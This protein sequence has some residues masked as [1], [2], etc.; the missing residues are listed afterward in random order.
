MSN[1]TTSPQRC[2]A[3]TLHFVDSVLKILEQVSELTLSPPKTQQQQQQQQDVFQ[4]PQARKRS[5]SFLV[6]PPRPQCNND[7]H[8]HPMEG[9]P[10]QDHHLLDDE[11]GLDAHATSPMMMMTD[12][13]DDRI[14]TFRS[15]GNHLPLLPDSDSLDE[16]VGT[17]RMNRLVSLRQHQLYPPHLRRLPMMGSY[18]PLHSPLQGYTSRVNEEFL[19]LAAATTTTTSHPP[20]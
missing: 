18:R 9:H 20:N 10:A 4:T 12:E 17:T 15:R 1:T 5:L 7:S 19:G 16:E 11:S 2:I 13:D 3:T 8:R 6:T 14:F